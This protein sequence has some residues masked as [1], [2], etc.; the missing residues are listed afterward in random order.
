MILRVW[1]NFKNCRN[2]FIDKKLKKSNLCQ[3]PLDKLREMWYT[4]DRNRKENKMLTKEE[5]KIQKLIRQMQGTNR[6]KKNK[7]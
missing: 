4:R 6:Y 7:N 5:K 2:L 1:G 3:K